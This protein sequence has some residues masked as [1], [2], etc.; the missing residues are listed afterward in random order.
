M[1]PLPSK[2]RNIQ[3]QA[4]N[5]PW[6][7]VNALRASLLAIISMV[8]S[9]SCKSAPSSFSASACGCG[10]TRWAL[11]SSVQY[12]EFPMFP[13]RRCKRGRRRNGLLD[14]FKLKRY[15]CRTRMLTFP[16][17]TPRPRERNGIVPRVQNEK[18]VAYRPHLLLKCCRPKCLRIRCSLKLINGKDIEPKVR[19]EYGRFS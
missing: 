7:D 6:P 1:A 11:V 16:T 5:G 9:A 15:C 13:Q 12:L 18:G 4:A 10:M 14:Q 8:L 17:H 3:Q 2:L 19:L